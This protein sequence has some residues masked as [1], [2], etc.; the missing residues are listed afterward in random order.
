MT[1]LIFMLM[2]QY[3]I[4]MKAG[5]VNHVEGGVNIKATQSLE[6][7]AP[8]QTGAGGFAEILLNP[9]SYLR[10]GENSEAV[11]DSIDLRNIAVRIVSGSAAIEAVGVDKRFPLKVTT[12]DLATEIIKNGIY[13]FADG[14]VTIVQGALRAADNKKSVFKK[15]RQVS[16][17]GG[18]RALK[19]KKGDVTPVEAWSRKR[20]KLIAVANDNIARSLRGTSS[21]FAVP[22]DGWLWVPGL[23]GYTYIPT[24][25]G[26]RSPYGYNYQTLSQTDYGI[27]RGNDAGNGNSIGNNGSIGDLNSSPAPDLSPNVGAIESVG[28]P[29]TSGGGIPVQ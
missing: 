9:G 2:M 28:E 20:S 12:G 22:W 24:D 17:D 21:S 27:S 6:A 15:G 14:R 16:K 10:L 3:V 19:V 13:A 25:Y 18:Y 29:A 4:S 11:L 7:G 26:F 5:L 1:S 8:I 23:G